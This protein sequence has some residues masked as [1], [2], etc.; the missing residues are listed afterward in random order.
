MGQGFDVRGFWETKILGWEDGR[1][2]EKATAPGVLERIADR[3]SASLRF[4]LASTGELLAPHVP[5]KRVVDVGCGSGLLGRA[6]LDAGASSYV[7]Y[8][9]AESAI[10]LARK[11]A[12]DLAWGERARFERA[13]IDELTPFDADVVVSLGLTDWLDDAGLERLFALGGPAHFLHAISERRPSVQRLLHQ[14][15]CWVS[16]G[17]RTQGYVPRYLDPRAIAAMAAKHRPGAPVYIWR[18]PRLSFGAY[19]TSLPL[20]DATPVTPA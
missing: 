14:A 9:I 19:L 16:Y 12:Q 2:E 17:Y 20:P 18:D 13:S 7:G 10:D 1:Y 3:A 6:L 5:G 4:R 11:R 15:Y 8:D